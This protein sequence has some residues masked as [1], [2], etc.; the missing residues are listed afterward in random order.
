MMTPNMRRMI[1][2]IDEIN[3]EGIVRPTIREIRTRMGINS[4]STTFRVLRL[5]EKHGFILRDPRASGITVI[6]RG[7]NVSSGEPL[8]DDPIVMYIHRHQSENRGQT[9]SFRQIAS[10]VGPSSLSTIY[11]SIHRLADRGF[12]ILGDKN[13]SRT[14]RVVKKDEDHGH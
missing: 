14:I 4:V 3:A 7:E 12:L 5:L 8:S 6:H 1:D 13:H 2:V 9:P 10:A 11:R